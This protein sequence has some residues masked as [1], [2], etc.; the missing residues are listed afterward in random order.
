MGREF[1][2]CFDVQISVG[3]HSWVLTSAEG[4][5][6]S[7]MIIY[8]HAQVVPD[9]A[10]RSPFKVALCPLVSSHIERKQNLKTTSLLSGPTRRLGLFL[11]LP[12][13]YPGSSCFC[14]APVRGE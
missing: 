5:W 12:C 1:S 8:F 6:F 2:L 9:K 7:A 13:R 14:L 4:L 3:V 11:P 10:S